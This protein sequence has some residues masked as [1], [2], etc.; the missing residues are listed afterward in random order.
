MLAAIGHATLQQAVHQAFCQQAHH[1]RVTTKGAVA[2][3]TAL[4]IVQ[5]QHRGEA[6]VHTAGPQLGSQ[7]VT[8]GCGRIRGVQRARVLFRAGRGHPH[9]SQR[10]HRRQVGKA[11]GLESLHAPAFVV[12]TNQQIGAHFLD[13]PAQGRELRAVLPIARKQNQ[14]ADQRVLEALAVNLGQARAGDIDDQGSVKG[15]GPMIWS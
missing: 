10:P 11:I 7:H 15:H 5:V 3:D 12:D 9:L 8:T 2:N 14:A 1:T 13:V 4:A 6:Q